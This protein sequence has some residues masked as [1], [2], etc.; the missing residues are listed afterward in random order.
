MIA[1]TYA[2]STLLCLSAH[3]TAGRR[4]RFEPLPMCLDCVSRED[5]LIPG[6][7]FDLTTAYATVAIRYYDGTVKNLAKVGS[8]FRT[9]AGESVDNIMT[10]STPA[11][12]T[13]N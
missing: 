8:I 4:P 11:M 3:V 6:I 1:L 5:I 2:L 10:R 9:S 12:I 13:S 7:G